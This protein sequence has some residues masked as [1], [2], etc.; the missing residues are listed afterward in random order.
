MSDLVLD[1]GAVRSRPSTSGLQTE[2]IRKS[3]D[4]RHEKELN[5]VR[6]NAEKMVKDAGHSRVEILKPAC[7]GGNKSKHESSEY[8]DSDDEFFHSTAHVDQTLIEKIER[9]NFVDL[10]KLLPKEKVLHHT[11]CLSVIN[12]DGISYFIPA[13]KKKH[14]W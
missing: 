4:I 14:L 8:S 2:T 7:R 1:E 10:A 5:D 12:K 11:E 13:M 6:R 3:M 9:G